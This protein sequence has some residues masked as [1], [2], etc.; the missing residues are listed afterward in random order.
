VTASSEPSAQTAPG[1]SDAGRGASRADLIATVLLSAATVLTAWSAFQASKWNGVQADRTNQAAASRTESV[2]ASTQAG[3]LRVIDATV[4]TAWLTATDQRQ[5]GLADQLAERF[6]PEFDIAFR[7]WQATSPL[8]NP[9]APPTPFAMPEYRLAT[10]Q[11][12][13]DLDAR[14]ASEVREASAAGERAD[15]YVLLTVLFAAVLFFGA[16]SIRF[17]ASSIQVPLLAAAIL[18]FVVSAIITATYPI[19]V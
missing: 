10:A 8:T 14:A 12:A 5:T 6:R 7:A 17:E 9:S 11:R 19:K 15:N 1:R 2:R 18:V 3:Q 4:F 16:M 13:A